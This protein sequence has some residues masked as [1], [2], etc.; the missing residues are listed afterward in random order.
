M[1]KG[2]DNNII[3][4]ELLSAFLDGNATAAESYDILNA[5]GDDAE[6]RE[7]LRISQEIDAEFGQCSAKILGDSYKKFK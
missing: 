5:L 7:I 2:I 1:N 3:S 6:L 4:S